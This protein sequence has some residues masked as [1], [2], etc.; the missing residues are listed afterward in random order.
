MKYIFQHEILA[1]DAP[2]TSAQWLNHMIIQLP[3]VQDD[4]CIDGCLGQSLGVLCYSKQEIDRSKVLVWT[5]EGPGNWVVKHCLNMTDVSGRD[6]L[7]SSNR[8][9][10]WYF[11]FVGILGF[12]LEREIVIL[13]DK[14][15]NKIVSVSI[16]TGKGSRFLKIPKKFTELYR[17]LFYVPYYGDVPAL[18][19]S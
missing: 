14:Q 11:H 16:S 1:L 3:G 4:G 13:N 5:M 6:K 17:S 7:I 18:V 12:D 19:C 10:G 9:G 15:A 8:K 2:D